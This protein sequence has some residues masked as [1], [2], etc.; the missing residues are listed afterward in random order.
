[1]EKDFNPIKDL[2]S[3]EGDPFN[4]PAGQSTQEIEAIRLTLVSTREKTE[5]LVK[6]LKRKGLLFK[7]DVEKIKELQRRLRKTIPRI[8]ILRDDFISE[9]TTIGDMKGGSE[10]NFRPF[11][12]PTQTTPTPT[13]TPVRFPWLDT[14]ITI[15]IIFG[16]RSKGGKGGTGGGIKLPQWLK[17]F[18]KNRKT[19]TNPS[20]TP[21]GD[22]LA[23]ILRKLIEKERLKNTPNPVRIDALE[24]ALSRVRIKPKITS[25][26]VD[27][28]IKTTFNREFNNKSN[29]KITKKLA[30]DSLKTQQIADDVVITIGNRTTDLKGEFQ[31]VDDTV[32]LLRNSIKNGDS[33]T[34]VKLTGDA[35]FG[36][37][38]TIRLQVV[39]ALK[40]VKPNSVNAKNLK[41]FLRKIDD[42]VEKANEV[43][44]PWAKKNNL[45]G[46]PEIL[47]NLKNN[48]TGAFLNGGS[49]SNDIA[50]LNIDTRDREIYVIYTDSIG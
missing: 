22:E 25:G 13:P 5:N 28:P 20:Q 30:K 45:I 7:Q 46:V 26:K 47:K 17:K 34:N 31:M 32:N 37:L 35:T 41:L 29:I 14:L 11:R 21:D 18:F 24:K 15:G 27:Q 38:S 33:I 49:M 10:L 48:T 23:E 6:L 3:P 19:T 36:S 43:F 8:P 2:R 12:K 44:S 1:M 16:L 39:E 40:S 9:T 50:S 42:G 4:V